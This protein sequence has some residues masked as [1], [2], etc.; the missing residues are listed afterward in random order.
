MNL[1]EDEGYFVGEGPLAITREFAIMSNFVNSWTTIDLGSFPK[2]ASRFSRVEN[3]T[4]IMNLFPLGENSCI[5][6][7]IFHELLDL[8]ILSQKDL[9]NL[10]AVLSSKT[11]LNLQL[12][13]YLSDNKIGE[14]PPLLQL[15][16]GFFPKELKHVELNIFSLNRTGKAV[17]VYCS[18][19]SL[20]NNLK[21]YHLIN[22]IQIFMKNTTHFVIAKNSSLPPI[23]KDLSSRTRET[24][25]QNP[26][27]SAA[28]RPKTRYSLTPR[29]LN[30]DKQL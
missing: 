1:R 14:A 3:F 15:L 10:A 24:T 28:K 13:D 6:L 27:E 17:Q 29:S 9:A 30:L 11:P 12:M 21:N 26:D 18:N 25:L 19:E 22:L 7:C 4:Q 16:A 2:G 5:P 20:R 8:N 23:F